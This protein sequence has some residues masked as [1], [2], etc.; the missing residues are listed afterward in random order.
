L[1]NPL[2]GDSPV[3]EPLHVL[4]LLVVASHTPANRDEVNV[5]ADN[6]GVENAIHNGLD[7]LV[8]VAS[9]PVNKE[10]KVENGEV[11]SRVVV[12]HVSNTSHNNKR[13]VVKKP[14]GQ[15]VQ[16]RVV[17]VVNLVLAEIV[18]T[19][20][21]SKDV[22]DNDQAGDSKRSGRTPVDERVTEE[23]VLDDIITPTAHTET[24]VKEWPLPPL[25][26][27]VIL[28]VR[29]GDQSVVGGHHSD[30]QMDEVMEEG[31]LV[32]TSLGGRD[33]MKLA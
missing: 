17:N 30:V 14:A 21:P 24:D 12:M 4:V 7:G 23:E 20:L 15:G 25:G 33:Y 2:V 18:D 29:I 28:L 26:S 22:P 32:N 3:I 9:E 8:A 27:K 13:K 1:I 11:E 5:K 16:C 31:G 19:S 10:A 6:D